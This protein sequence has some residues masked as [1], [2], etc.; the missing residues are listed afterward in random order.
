M[1]IP[2]SDSAVGALDSV[3]A[4]HAIATRNAPSP[5]SD[6]HRPANSSRKSRSRRTLLGAIGRSRHG[7]AGLDRVALR[8]AR[9]VVDQVRRL[10]R[11]REVEALAELAAEI[12]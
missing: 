5:S 6:T 7:R 9:Q 8:P 11:V 3:Y 2:S 4:S 10:H 12:A 1:A